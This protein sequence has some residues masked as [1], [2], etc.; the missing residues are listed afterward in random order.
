MDPRDDRLYVA[1]GGYVAVYKADGSLEEINE[2]QHVT[3]AIATGGTFKLK[4]K[5]EETAP[6]QFDAGAAEVEAA[7]EALVAVGAGNVE[8]QKPGSVHLVTF[9]GALAHSDVEMLG[10]DP[11]GLVGSGANITVTET[12]KGFNGHVGEGDLTDATGV[13]VYTH[14]T[15]FEGVDHY[16]FA[17]DSAT[18]RV[19]VFRGPNVSTMTLS[20]E[21]EGPEGGPSFDFEG[22]DAYLAADPGNGN[23]LTTKKCAAT[24]QAC[25]AGHL[26]VYDPG[27]NAISEFEATGEFLDQFTDPTL[28]NA[29]PTAIAVDRSGGA[30]DGTVYVT[31]GPGAGAKLLAFGPLVPPGRRPLG[32]P[33]SKVLSTARSVA[34]DSQGN[35]YVG[36]GS[37]V[38]VF[39]PD[40]KE[41]AVGPTGKGIPTTQPA[42]DLAVDSACRLYVLEPSPSLD[43]AEDRVNYYTPSACP[44]QTGTQYAGPTTIA[45]G[46]SFTP[47]EEPNA[48]GLNP[49]NEHVFV[50]GRFTSRMIELSS[51]AEGSLVLDPCFGCG[52]LG[53]AAIQDISPYGANGNVY[54]AQSGTISLIDP[55][56]PDDVEDE[57]VAARI[58]GAGSPKGAP[59]SPAPK[60]AVDQSNGHVL[61]FHQVRG[62][63][64]EYEAS[65]AFVAEF[66]K[67]TTD[68]PGRGRIAIDNSGGPGDGR[69]Y[70]AYDDPSEPFDLVAF[71]PLSYGEP[72]SVAT[73]TASGLGGGDATLNGS[74]DPRGFALA[75]CHFEYLSDAQYEA[76]GKG[77]AG[78]TSVPCA[79]TPAEIGEGDEPVP[80][81]ADLTGLD[82]AERYRFRLLAANE[83]GAD[84]GEAGLFGPPLIAGEE[85]LPILYDEATL[86]AE[87]D[88][89]GLATEYRFEYVTEEAFQAAGESFGTGTLSTPVAGLPPGDGP[90]AVEAALTGL[91]EGTA[92]RFRLLA[93]N[94]ALAA[95]GPAQAFATLQR[96]GAQNCPN[97]EFRTGLSAKLPDCRAYEMVT[98][99][100]TRGLI[101]GA[102]IGGTEGDWFNN[103]LVAPRGPLAGESVAYFIGTLPGFE[104]SGGVDGYRALR[105]PGP[106]PASGWSTSLFG[107]SYAQVGI[108]GTGQQHGVAADQLHWLY[109]I[110]GAT[111]ALA[112]TLPDGEY[113]RAPG[114]L[115][116]SPCNPTP[117]QDDFELIGCGRLGTDPGAHSRLLT[118]GGSHVVFFSGAHLEPA[119]APASTTTVYDRGVGS[120]EAEV[121][122]LKPGGGAFGAGEDSTYL[123]ATE[124]GEAVVFSVAGALYLHRGGETVQVSDAPSS[125][126]GLAEDGGRVFFIDATFSGL[127]PPPATLFACD[128]AGGS[129]AGSGKAQEPTEIAKD[130][131]F[132]S[133]SPDGSR[134]LYVAEEAGEPT[135]RSWEEG[136]TTD[137]VGA[138]HPQ[139]LIGFSGE[140]SVNLARWA[141]AVT[142]GIRIGRNKS[143]TRSTPDG[144]VFAFQSHAQ[145]TPYE[146]EGHSEVYRYE[147]G[148]PP[149][150]Q[151]ICVSCDPS[152]ATSSGE[153][154]LLVNSGDGGVAES[155]TLVPNLTDDGQAIFFQ[156]ADRLLP[157]D[158]NDVQDVYEWKAQGYRGCERPGGCLAL[159]SSG[160]GDKP[161]F[162][163][164][165]SA[166]GH[167]VFLETP[168]KLVAQDAPGSHSIYD[169]RVEGG[170]PDPPPP[171]G[172]QGDACQGRG[173]VA[174]GLPSPA[175]AAGSGE[176]D[177]RETRPRPPCPKG[178]RRVARRGKV[179]C[180]KRQAKRRPRAESKRRAAR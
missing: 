43:L 125:F 173:T 91:A 28:E 103:W 179:R 111:E 76:N 82:P 84:A 151:L 105:G 171:Q 107:P 112:E 139:D 175:S 115:A 142:A 11:S 54:I 155:T 3:V 46:N 114:G 9:T 97:V 69:A 136:G 72:P 5:G 10:A 89:S 120:D 25:T 113:L 154:E 161:S 13:G 146:N 51:V 12:T 52:L 45:N 77:F 156:S 98:P 1:K 32:E 26:F 23:P 90:V 100:D 50:G 137:L 14:P 80:V 49:V 29:K 8:V 170:I 144:E 127:N 157:E 172:C 73:G 2:V 66:G 177:V 71:A 87:I 101:P 178:K 180:V 159:I 118:P 150:E 63:A 176:G 78:A 141:P 138:L 59:L 64:E 30:G 123:A 163:Y 133:V 67:F 121:I 174:P 58:T 160:Q 147:P 169:A 81:H 21:I 158:A 16:V 62:V 57:K 124:D 47:P 152:G 93:E 31:S 128:V 149:G 39:G 68:A 132:A 116:A 36:T 119:A 60:I 44:P 27:A 24:E 166:D 104:G 15:I 17:A 135:L 55:M 92:Y 74:V 134:A 75:E 7:L 143:P 70:I 126:A 96:A 37:L 108:D 53:S 102:T 94:E 99:A 38:R 34:V 145:L 117:S 33:L 129:C 22:A 110:G 4:F 164:G 131:I 168:E 130:A 122:S 56:D 95:E 48:I 19:S 61:V 6:I 42:D 140:V 88:P 83:F 85:A 41:I 18:D 148:A 65:G 35:V 79:E 162:L 165:M 86:R 106:H 167:D 153:D 40:G 20:R 109:G